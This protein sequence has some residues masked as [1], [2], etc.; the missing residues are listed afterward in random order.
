MCVGANCCEEK[1]THSKYPSQPDSRPGFATFPFL[2]TKYHF[3]DAGSLVCQH[4]R[5]VPLQPLVGLLTYQ[6]LDPGHA[7]TQTVQALQSS[8]MGK[9]S[10]RARYPVCNRAR[11]RQSTARIRRRTAP[12]PAGRPESAEWSWRQRKTARLRL[13]VSSLGIL[14]ELSRDHLLVYQRLVFLS[15]PPRIHGTGCAC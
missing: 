7:L 3:Q 10:P 9:G 14:G 4:S 13:L 2:D 15:N 6:Q 5:P 11:W 12:C 8:L 1:G